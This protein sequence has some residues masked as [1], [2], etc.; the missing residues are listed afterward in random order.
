M[1]A[2]LLDDIRIEADE[3]GQSADN[4]FLGE[5]VEDGD[6]ETDVGHPRVVQFSHTIDELIARRTLLGEDV[7]HSGD[8]SFGS[9]GAVLYQSKQFRRLHAHASDRLIQQTQDRS[10]HIG[11]S[12]HVHLGQPDDV[13]LESSFRVFQVDFY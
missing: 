5:P 2:Y 7:Y 10:L 3:L 13:I 11:N 9:L 8:E 1:L 6:E 4:L 12:L